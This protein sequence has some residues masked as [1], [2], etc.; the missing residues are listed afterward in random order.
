MSKRFH[1]YLNHSK[2]ITPTEAIATNPEMISLARDLLVFGTQMTAAK[3]NISEAMFLH[4]T[5]FMS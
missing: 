5:L 1:N 2:N 4:V 3:G